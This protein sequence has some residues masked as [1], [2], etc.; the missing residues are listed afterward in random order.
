MWNISTIT[1]AYSTLFTL[2]ENRRKRTC[3]Y[4]RIQLLIYS[5]VFFFFIIP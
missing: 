3:D 2:A 1:T 4:K 5:P